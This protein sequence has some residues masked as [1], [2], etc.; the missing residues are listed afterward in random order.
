MRVMMKVAIPTEAGNRGIAEGALPKTVG[1]F[2]ETHRPEAAYFAAQ[3]GKRTALFFFDL[4]DTTSI[5]S[6]CEPF[7]ANLNA[8]IEISPVMNADE[9]RAGVER[10]MKQR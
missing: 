10:A 9:M 1:A 5:P 7:F 6:I 2:L 4:K 3:N 8:E